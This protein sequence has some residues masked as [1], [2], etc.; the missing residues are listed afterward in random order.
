MELPTDPVAGVGHDE[1]NTHRYQLALEAGRMGTWYWDSAQDRLDWDEQLMQV[2]GVTADRFEGTFAAY[3]ALL[4]ENDV[5]ATVATVEESL[6]TGRDHYVEHRVVLPD[7]EVRWVSG[8]GRVL[9]DEHG[10]VTG[11]VGV[12][13]DIT[14][15]HALHEARLAAEA[16]TEIAPGRVGGRGCAAAHPQAWRRASR[17]SR[18][19]ARRPRAVGAHRGV[20]RRGPP[21]RGRGDDPAQ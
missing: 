18:R 6:R 12:G 13:A 7:G 15:Q 16:A 3:L 4:H 1:V 14:E 8:T 5:A 20:V 21:R 2:F 17:G 10:A 19:T 11:M 9:T